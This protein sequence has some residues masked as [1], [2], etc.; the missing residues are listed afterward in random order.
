M[1]RINISKTVLT[2]IYV[3]NDILAKK[4]KVWSHF[5]NVA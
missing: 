3:S 4:K 1:K 2:L 5:R